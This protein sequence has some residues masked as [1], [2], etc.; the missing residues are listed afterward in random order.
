MVGAGVAA[1]AFVAGDGELDEAVLGR[2][3]YRVSQ[4]E[5]GLVQVEVGGRSFTPQEIS[6]L[7]LR[8]VAAQA[9]AR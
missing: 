9:T 1:L 7:I 2:L 5:R 4:T 3:P 6:A 8:E